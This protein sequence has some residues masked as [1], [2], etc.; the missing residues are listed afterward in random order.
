MAEAP[1]V[2]ATAT[3]VLRLQARVALDGFQRNR[4]ANG[5]KGGWNWGLRRQSALSE[6]RILAFANKN[7]ID[8]IYV[9]CWIQ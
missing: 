1:V 6:V 4:S 2:E 3:E 5:T 8:Q 9:N 7:Y